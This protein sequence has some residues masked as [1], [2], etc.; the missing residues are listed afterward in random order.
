[1][2]RPISVTTKATRKKPSPP[3]FRLKSLAAA[4]TVRAKTGS[5]AKCS[6]RSESRFPTW[7]LSLELR[8]FEQ[9][10]CKT[11]PTMAN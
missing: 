9:H 5:S 2:R 8:I 6:A 1:M 4:V 11:W 3:I 7:C 10:R